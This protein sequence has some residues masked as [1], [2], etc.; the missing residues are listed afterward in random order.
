MIRLLAI[1]LLLAVPCSAQT[2]C[3]CA[4][5]CAARANVS[6]GLAFD[7]SM[8]R[9][10]FRHRFWNG[11]C[12]SGLPFC[13][14]GE[15]WYDVMDVVLAKP[16]VTDPARTCETLLQLGRAIGHEWAKDNDVRSIHTREFRGWARRLRATDSPDALLDEIATEV[17]ARLAGK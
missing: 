15:G 10:W 2:P 9:D 8:H 3:D 11:T 16:A 13:W 17:E 1:A 4:R 14:S 7:D 6:A 5:D 12:V